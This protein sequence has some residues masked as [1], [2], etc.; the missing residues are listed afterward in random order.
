[1]TQ[2]FRKIRQGNFWGVREQP[3]N[4]LRRFFDDSRRK[5]RR[6][7][8]FGRFSDLQTFTK[9]RACQ[10]NQRFS[11]FEFEATNTS[12]KP[13]SGAYFCVRERFA[14]AKEPQEGGEKPWTCAISKFCEQAIFVLEKAT[15]KNEFLGIEELRQCNSGGPGRG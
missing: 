11:G 13:I 1:M 8:I 9:Y 3:A 15:Q 4:A 7:S 5:P 14:Q 12:R 6:M 10:Q 2:N